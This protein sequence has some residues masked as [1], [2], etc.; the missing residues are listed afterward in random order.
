VLLAAGVFITVDVTL[1]LAS[2]SG[3]SGKM[4]YSLGPVSFLGSVS[5]FVNES[6]LRE[7]LCDGGA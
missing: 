6:A 4:M 2:S 5:S 3:G 1:G 7:L